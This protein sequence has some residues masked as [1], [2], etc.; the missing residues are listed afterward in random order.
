MLRLLD[1]IQKNPTDEKFRSFS[2]TNEKIRTKLLSMHNASHLL[3]SAGFSENTQTGRWSFTGNVEGLKERVDAV[4]RWLSDERD[5]RF[6][7]ERDQRIRAEKERD[8]R[9]GRGGSVGGGGSGG[10]FSSSSSTEQS[11]KEKAEILKQLE[12]DRK[13]REAEGKLQTEMRSSMAASSS[14]SRPAG[15]AMSVR[16]LPGGALVEEAVDES[17][18]RRKRAAPKRNSMAGSSFFGGAAAG[19]GA[20]RL[21]GGGGGSESSSDFEPQPEEAIPSEEEEEGEGRENRPSKRKKPRKSEEV[22]EF[23]KAASGKRATVWDS[24]GRRA[25][26]VAARFIQTVVEVQEQRAVTAGHAFTQVSGLQRIEAAKKGIVKIE[27]MAESSGKKAASKTVNRG[28]VLYGVSSAAK[29]KEKWEEEVSVY[30]SEFLVDV[31]AEVI[32]KSSTSRRRAAGAGR[33]NIEDIARCSPS[34]FWTLYDLFGE[35]T[36]V[37]DGLRELMERGLAFVLSADSPGDEEAATSPA[38]AA[39]AAAD[40][41]DNDD[42]ADTGQGGEESRTEI[43]ETNGA[44]GAE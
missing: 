29:Q 30:T 40:D 34:M 33:L 1:T 41:V 42:S 44:N 26:D 39:P 35:G 16:V 4:S 2:S 6:R 3:S 14:S 18:D 15:P 5:A 24:E 13:E 27:K 19:G 11:G 20:R 17:R 23:E 8:A 43:G 37:E 25:K 28:R 7:R 9:E 38:A 10:L 22:K 31:F 36:G 21:S 12:A 32:R